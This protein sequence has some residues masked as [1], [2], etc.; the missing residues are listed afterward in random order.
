MRIEIAKKDFTV[1]SKTIKVGLIATLAVDILVR[2]DFGDIRN[3]LSLNKTC[4]TVKD[5]E[6]A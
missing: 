6:V 5:A 1:Q 3:T 2:G 4:L